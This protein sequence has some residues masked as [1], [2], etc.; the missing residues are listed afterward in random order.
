MEFAQ[1]FFLFVFASFW[2]LP[3]FFNY[4]QIYLLE[5]IKTPKLSTMTPEPLKHRGHMHQAECIVYVHRCKDQIIQ[6]LPGEAHCALTGRA[7]PCVHGC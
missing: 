4:I 6:N 1:S 5:E 7:R 2:L 3:I